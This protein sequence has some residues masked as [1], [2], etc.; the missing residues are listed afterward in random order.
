MTFAKGFDC[1][2][3]CGGSG[4]AGAGSATV[5]ILLSDHWLRS[6]NT[7]EPVPELFIADAEADAEYWVSWQ[8]AWQCNG[9]STTGI[10]LRFNGPAAPVIACMVGRIYNTDTGPATTWT[11][12]NMN[13]YLVVASNGSGANQDLDL[14]IEIEG[15]FMNGPNVGN[16]FLEAAPITNGQ[17]VQ[18]RKNSLLTYKR[19]F[20][21]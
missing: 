21:A 1:A 17:Q 8:L 20:N 3:P 6:V 15:L 4:G 11:E 18:I 9:V 5:D 12:T 16:F 10:Q 7:F 14:K 13:T 2:S 19:Y